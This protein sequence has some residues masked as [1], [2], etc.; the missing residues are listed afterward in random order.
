MSQLNIYRASAGSGKTYT[1]TGEFLNLVFKDPLSYKHILAVTFTNK[2][3]DEMKS[4]ILKEIHIISSGSKSPYAK[5]LCKANHLNSEELKIRAKEILNRLL[6]DY[7][8]FSVTTIDSFFQKIVRSFTREIGLQMGYNIEL[9]Q[10]RVLSDVIDL[11]LQDVDSDHQL[12]NWLSS[13]AESK[14]RDGKT[15]NFK[16][17]VLTLGREVFKEDFQ[18]FSKKLVKKLSDKQFLSV[19]RKTLNEI[20]EDFEQFFASKGNEALRIM[21][22]RS[23][24]IADF[25]YG[26]TGV[27]G[28]LAGLGKAGKYEPGAR[29]R[30][31]IDTPKKWV[32]SK[33]SKEI[34]L[35]V[36]EA[37]AGGL[38]DI[39]KEVVSYYDEQSMLYNSTEKTLSYIYTL[40]IL[41]DLSKKVR[42]YSEDENIFLLSDASRLLRDIIGKNDSPFIYE[43]I[44]N[45]YKHFMI[46]E[47]Q[48][49]SSMQWDNFRPLVGNSLAED[50][51]SLVVGDVKQSI[52]RWRNGDWKLL[53]NRLDSDFKGFGVNALSLNHN[54]RSAANVIDFNNSIF[55]LG[56]QILQNAYND[57]IPSEISDRM[58]DEKQKILSA[59][60]DVYQHFPQ[61]N[62]SLKGY[63]KAHFLENENE[64]DWSEQV[65]AE[66][67]L[68]IEELQASGYHAK[69]IAILVRNGKEGGLVADSLMHYRA[70]ENAKEDINYDVISNDSLYLKNS[71]SVNFLMHVLHY[72][73]Y[74][75]DKINIGFL[76]QEYSLYITEQTNC[77][78]DDLYEYCNHNQFNSIFPEEFL[79]NINELKRQPLY[80]LTEK[81]IKLFN[82]N[83]NSNEF[84]FL[85]AFQDLVLGFTKSDS[86]DLN[87]FVQFWEERKDKEVISVSDEQDAIRIMT[88]HKSKGLEF[89][90]VILPFANWDL[91]NTRHTNILWCQ[92]KVEGFNRL[93]V[94]PV[95]YS[96][97]LKDTIYYQEYFEEKLQS[98]IDNLNLLYVAQTRAEEVFVSYSPV[99]KNKD[100]KTVADLLLFVFRNANNY[101][102]DFFGNSI[103]AIADYWN[104]EDKC[105]EI[106]DLP[107]IRSDKKKLPSSKNKEYPAALLD[108]RL[109][110]RSHSAD[111]F[112]FSRAE[113][114]E[115]FSPVSRGNILHQLFQLIEYADDIEKAVEQLKFEGKLDEAQADEV[116]EFAKELLSEPKVEEWFSKNW[117][118]IN[119]RDILKGKGEVYRP[120]RVIL[121][122]NKAIVI[123]YKFGKKKT[124]AHEKQ[125]AQYKN[126]LE[127]LGMEE[128][129]A[130]L[131][132]G[133]LS[134][135]VSV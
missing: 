26:K 135:I 32:A 45:V 69:D 1:L 6:H 100:L 43:K 70:S 20:K 122:G 7:S 118:V 81:L 18:N 27:T 88:I 128:V 11:L 48:D 14:I 57:S 38:N 25:S 33:A 66:L 107:S 44:G 94:L 77:T 60:R 24:G 111:Y 115:S 42:E 101:S 91:D 83:L 116:Q 4:R 36:E 28:Y 93:D 78:S 64:L 85:E 31:A 22:T 112:D 73:V 90:A 125:V 75:E 34:K 114:V 56:A 68:K 109:K 95:R 102:T 76:K 132:Y 15:W 79:E 89:K 54:W 67:P 129:E 17:D 72:L 119:E 35:A 8:R 49:T 12:R 39:L 130:Y 41:T 123:D 87:S 104:E 5:E 82:L 84:P 61:K 21:E 46:D 23:L 127:A 37:V 19:Y 131:L 9:D 51:H 62:E 133:K 55:A 97:S 16:Q 47:F 63:V 50:E 52:Y 110:L 117:K 13:F 58:E 65:L 80:D 121:K 106:G 74:P 86:P 134:E 59:Y 126:L 40:G 92:P 113:S 96:S 108:D 71:S 3:T 98:Y 99:N 2:A 105:L 30:A 120:D 10:G 103:I 124:K 53:A 29:A